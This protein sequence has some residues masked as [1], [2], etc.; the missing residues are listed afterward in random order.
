M[1]LVRSLLYRWQQSF[2][3]LPWWTIPAACWTCVVV[4][5]LIRVAV[6]PHKS[7]VYPTFSLAGQHFVQGEPIYGH[8]A[9][10][11]RYSPAWAAFFSLGND[12]HVLVPNY[13][14]RLLNLA[15]LLWGGFRFQR[16]FLP[17]W[18]LLQ[19]SLWWTLMFPLCYGSFNNAQANLLLLG[20]LM[21]GLTFFAQRRYWLSGF[22]WAVTISM[23]VYPVALP[24]LLLLLEPLAVLG[25]LLVWLA[26]LGLLPF[27]FQSA[28]Y[29]MSEYRHW[30][31]FSF[32]DLRVEK[33]LSDSNRDAWMLFRLSRLPL[34]YFWYQ[35][36]QAITAVSLAF[37]TW[38]NRSFLKTITT[39][40]IQFLK[41]F[42]LA[43]AW[44]LIFG[45]A[46]ESS[47]YSLAAPLASYSMVTLL[48]L[49]TTMLE[50]VLILLSCLL[51][52]LAHLGSAFTYTSMLHA[53]GIHPIAAIILATTVHLLLRSPDRQTLPGL[54]T[55][56]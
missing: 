53:W 31:A 18:S 49:S 7:T 20:L 47:T 12:L 4:I 56:P 9:A 28:S 39:A 37:W 8:S 22:Y 33:D 15:V 1:S 23:K 29:V 25:P 10:I 43:I 24:L 19:Q 17:Q 32:G 35:L 45:P 2:T 38:L 16:H 48:T 54:T 11:F 27:G 3:R 26:L 55:S 34:N 30:A 51:M 41:L 46:S 5:I 52:L 50:R 21:A 44:M 14:W 42:N 13:T 40:N 6:Q 36:I